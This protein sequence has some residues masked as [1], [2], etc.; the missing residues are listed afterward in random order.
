M[1]PS[2]CCSAGWGGLEKCSLLLLFGSLGRVCLGW[3]CGS[4]VIAGWGNYAQLDGGRAFWVGFGREGC[5]VLGMGRGR[6]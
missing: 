6:E 3:L 4:G 5:G 2:L 1:Q